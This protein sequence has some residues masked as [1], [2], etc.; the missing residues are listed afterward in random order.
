[1][2][3][4]LVLSLKVSNNAGCHVACNC[5]VVVLQKENSHLINSFILR[6]QRM[7]ILNI[8]D[9]LKIIAAVLF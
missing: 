7:I 8:A 3:R 1:M 6:S 5:G 9:L 4:Q 2:E